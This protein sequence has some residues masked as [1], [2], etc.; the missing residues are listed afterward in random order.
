MTLSH[1]GMGN[2]D[3]ISNHRNSNQSLYFLTNSMAGYKS[4]HYI[5]QHTGEGQSN[6]GGCNNL[7]LQNNEVIAEALNAV[8]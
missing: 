2:V 3:E 5:V 1:N 8:P 4:N 6:I 7:A